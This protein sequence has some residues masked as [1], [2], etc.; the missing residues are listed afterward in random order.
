FLGFRT[1]VPDLM[2]ACDLVAHTST[3]SEPFGRVIVEA[4]LCGRPVVAAAAGG[5]IEIVEHG[6]T[7]WLTPPGNAAKLADIITTACVHPVQADTIA[8][9][10]QVSAQQRFSLT[11]VNAQINGLLNSLETSTVKMPVSQHL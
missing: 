1:D 10:G 4:M 2:A 11:A 5:A 9:Q 3:A 7:G 8:Q 6:T